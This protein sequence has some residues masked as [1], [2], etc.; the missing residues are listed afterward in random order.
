MGGSGSLTTKE[1]YTGNK[2]AL[3]IEL[4]TFPDNGI[5]GGGLTLNNTRDGIKLEIN[6]NVGGSGSMK[7]HMYVMADALMEVINSNLKLILY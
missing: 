4:K 5:R 7:C 6:R 3:W 2:Y 1:F